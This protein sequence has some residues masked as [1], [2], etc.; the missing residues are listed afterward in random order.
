MNVREAV[1]VLLLVAC[2]ATLL[3]VVPSWL[4]GLWVALAVFIATWILS[5]VV[6]DAGIVDIVWGPA[7][8]LLGWFAAIT[9]TAQPGWRGM[10][11]CAMATL[12]A[13]RLAAHLV[14]RNMGRE[15]DFRYRTWREQW[16]G[17]FW[18]R[19]LLQVFVL[20]ACVAWVL[21]A[22]L[23]AAQRADGA[24]FGV[25]DAVGLTAWAFG[26]GWESVA[27]WQLL[28]FKRQPSNRGRVLRSGLWGL[29]RHPNYFGETVLWWGIALVGLAAGGP[30]AL[31]GPVLLTYLLL[32]ISG[33]PMLDEGLSRRKPGYAEYVRSTPAFLPI[34]RRWRS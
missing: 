25:L 8:A 1:F 18:W 28:R 34:P 16:G 3:V 4:A 14:A 33:V 12:W 30:V 17:S 2:G 24:A 5:L 9:V 22:P 20:Q 19:S 6:R 10:V 11:A 15:E 21:A 13:L 7:L 32:K 23:V 31:V 27:D 29:S 26:L